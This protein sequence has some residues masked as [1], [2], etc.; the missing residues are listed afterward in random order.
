MQRILFAIS[1]VPA[2]GQ[3]AFIH[4]MPESPRYDLMKGETGKTRKTFKI[5]YAG[6]SDDLIELKIAALREVV[7]VS[8]E[9]QQ[10]YNLLGRLKLV[11][12]KARYARPT[13]TAWCVFVLPSL[14]SELCN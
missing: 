7:N 6:A 1:L 12:T 3:A 2:I 14:A 5:V 11:C 9:F 4:Y 10:R 8:N 13:F